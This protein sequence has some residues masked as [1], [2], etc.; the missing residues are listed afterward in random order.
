M[1]KQF[2]LYWAVIFISVFSFSSLL[3]IPSEAQLVVTDAIPRE[4]L[5]FHIEYPTE[6]F[7][8]KEQAQGMEAYFFSRE[9]IKSQTDQYRAGISVM[10]SKGLASNVGNW[11]EFKQALMADSQAKGM[12]I[13]DM[14]LD[15]VDGYT[16]VAFIARSNRNHMCFVYIKKDKDLVGLVLESPK[17]EWENFKPVFLKTIQN[18]SFKKG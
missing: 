1:R 18:F 7:S 15:Q 4:D 16:A 2:S 11:N 9:Q 6:W 8:R 10:I 12:T 5:P 3:T 17:E 13:E 14:D